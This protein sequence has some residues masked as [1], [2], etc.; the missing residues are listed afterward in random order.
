L[1][2]LQEGRGTNNKSNK[3]D[4]AGDEEGP[5][6]ESKA[7]EFEGLSCEVESVDSLL[8]I[9]RSLMEDPEKSIT[10]PGKKAICVKSN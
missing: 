4:L 3:R 8:D 7:S 9:I 6:S 2:L 1:R 10:A 5:D